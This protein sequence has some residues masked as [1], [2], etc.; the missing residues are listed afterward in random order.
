MYLLTEHLI[1]HHLVRE[2]MNYV[3]YDPAFVR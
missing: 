3:K 1:T 2:V